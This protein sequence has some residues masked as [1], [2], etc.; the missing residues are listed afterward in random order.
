MIINLPIVYTYFTQFCFD[1]LYIEYIYK[2]PYQSTHGQNK[3]FNFKCLGRGCYTFKY[4]AFSHFI[5]FT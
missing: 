1:T 4:L 5:L 3:S 2:C